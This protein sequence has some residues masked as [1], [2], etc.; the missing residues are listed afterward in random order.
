MVGYSCE[1]LEHPLTSVAWYL[2]VP[3]VLDSWS[4]KNV[5]HPLGLH[6]RRYKN[7]PHFLFY[8]SKVIRSSS[9]VFISS[10]FLFLYYFK[11]IGVFFIVSKKITP[12]PIKIFIKLYNIFRIFF[13][14]LICLKLHISLSF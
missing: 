5:W 11:L 12:L 3:N 4:D 7:S 2:I 13:Y 1:L 14:D 10:L 9:Q 6:Q 8:F